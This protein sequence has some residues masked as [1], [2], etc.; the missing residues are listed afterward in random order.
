MSR[1]IRG[2]LMLFALGLTQPGTA[3]AFGCEPS[4]HHEQC[5]PHQDDSPRSTVPHGAANCA[6]M[7]TCAA[8]VALPAP[9]YAPLWG[10][11]AR[12]HTVSLTVLPQSRVDRPAN[13]PPRA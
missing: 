9:A 2:L 10:A 6:V 8:A 3:S 11:V 13:P 12:E 5:P 4:S 7:L 1:C